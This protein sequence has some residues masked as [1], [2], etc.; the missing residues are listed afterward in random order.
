MS[1]GWRCCTESFSLTFPYEWSE[2]SLCEC[3]REMN[4]VLERDVAV[5]A[6]PPLILPLGPRKI[7]Q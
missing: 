6:A 4:T 1:H 7:R 2:L 5:L 3:W